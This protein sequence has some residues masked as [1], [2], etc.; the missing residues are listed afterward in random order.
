[1]LK[2]MNEEPPFLKKYILNINRKKI[3]EK[4]IIPI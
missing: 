4:I 3:P 1:M 2:D